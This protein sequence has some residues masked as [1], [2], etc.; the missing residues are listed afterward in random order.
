MPQDY[1]RA[2]HTGELK[3][4][5]KKMVQIG[6]EYIL[7][8]NLGGSYYA[9]EGMCPHADAEL[10]YG[11]LY[12][13]ELVCPVHGS[14]FDVKTG[15]VLSPPAASGLTVYPVRVEGDEI[16]IGPPGG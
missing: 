15:D 10:S 16:L 9:V 14:T 1:V 5:K 8:V 6:D 12:G 7:L 2:A 4:G 13:D 11:Q 3:P